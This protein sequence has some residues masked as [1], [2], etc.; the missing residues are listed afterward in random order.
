LATIIIKDLRQPLW[1]PFFVV[2]VIRAFLKDIPNTSVINFF[3]CS[4]AS[5]AQPTAYLQRTSLP[6]PG[7][8]TH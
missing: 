8:H 5:K 4:K 3:V 7:A 1:L 2:A 6:T